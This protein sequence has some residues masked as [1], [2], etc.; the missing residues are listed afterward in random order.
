MQSRNDQKCQ[1]IYVSKHSHSFL[2]NISETFGLW[3]VD[4]SASSYARPRWQ[5]TASRTRSWSRV[6]LARRPNTRSHL[7]ASGLKRPILKI[8]LR[9]D[10]SCI[11]QTSLGHLT[12]LITGNLLYHIPFARQCRVSST[13]NNENILHGNNL[14]VNVIIRLN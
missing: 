8:F 7:R 5:S 14:K 9:V 3:T 10:G 2:S 4:V 1:P 11:S 13:S 6:A 12:A